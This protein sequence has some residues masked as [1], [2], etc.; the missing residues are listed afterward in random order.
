VLTTY[1]YVRSGGEEQTGSSSRA[2]GSHELYKEIWNAQ[3]LP[4][5]QIFAWK[6]SQEGLVTQ[7]NRK[8]RTLME[9]VTCRICGVEDESDHHAVVKCTKAATLRFQLRQYWRLS[10]E[11]QL[12]QTGPDWL[13]LLLNSVDAEVKAYILLLFW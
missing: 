2:D 5:V 7:C 3:V 4:K 8:I 6:L 11:E 12:R 10:D 1:A 13:L 9:D